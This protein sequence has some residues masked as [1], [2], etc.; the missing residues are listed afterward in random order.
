MICILIIFLPYAGKTLDPAERL[1]FLSGP[2]RVQYPAEKSR[3]S[4]MTFLSKH[5]LVRH[6]PVKRGD[7]G[8]QLWSKQADVLRL[9][10][11][12]DVVKQPLGT[13]QDTVGRLP[14]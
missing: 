5:P 10:I 7:F 8:M 9:C 13:G 6:H 12:Y 3:E 4:P 14:H 1:P 2:A 11:P